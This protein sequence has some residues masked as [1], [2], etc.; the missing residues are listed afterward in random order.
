MLRSLQVT[1]EH[2]KPPPWLRQFDLNFEFEDLS[3]DCVE[4]QVV[5][6]LAIGIQLVGRAVD[7][8]V[9]IAMVWP[10]RDR[11]GS[12]TQRQLN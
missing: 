3:P 8:G 12:D 4:A 1:K 10:Q 7:K 6:W 5:E 11:G 2:C 9:C